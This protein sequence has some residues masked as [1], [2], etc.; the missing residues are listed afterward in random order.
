MYAGQESASRHTPSLFEID[1]VE[2]GNYSLQP[3]LARLAKLKKDPAMVGGK[4]VI[5]HSDPAIQAAW[6]LP[7]KSLYGIFNVSGK[8]GYVL[9]SL[10]DGNYKDVLTDETVSVRGSKLLLPESIFILRAP[11][12]MMLRP[13]YCELLDYNFTGR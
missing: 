11:E 9:T 13:A 5:T 4:F 7:G 12:L 1:K 10:P 2:W 6:E 3:L 8:Q